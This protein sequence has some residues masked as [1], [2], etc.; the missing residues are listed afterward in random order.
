MAIDKVIPGS[1]LEQRLYDAML[2]EMQKE[3]NGIAE[4][5]I[6]EAL[7]RIQSELR[8]RMGSMTLGLLQSSYSIRTMGHDLH[9]TVHVKEPKL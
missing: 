5:I 9:I 8:R 1:P 2:R 3:L 7:E 4:P 6:K